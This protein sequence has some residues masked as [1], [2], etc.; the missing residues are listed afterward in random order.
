MRKAITAM[1]LAVLISL[2]CGAGALAAGPDDVTGRWLNQDKDAAVDIYRCGNLYCGKISWLKE[3]NY[4][5]DDNKGM[6]GKQKVDRENPN[7]SLRSRPIMNLELLSSFQYM[8][9]NV[10][11]KG[12]IYDPKSGKTYKCKMTLEGNKLN[13]RGFIGISLI[14]RTN[15]WTRVQ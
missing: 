11:E 6:A 4:P 14:G 2:C 12:T 7:A 8:G 3:P 1:M 9:D 15:V 10:W 5:A 13:I